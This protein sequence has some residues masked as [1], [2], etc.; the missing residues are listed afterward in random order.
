MPADQPRTRTVG[1]KMTDSEYE[2]L[3]AGAAA[4]TYVPG[5]MALLRQA[6]DFVRGVMAKT[7]ATVPQNPAGYAGAGVRAAY[8]IL[9]AIW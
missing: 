3:A 1:C 9:K 8:K 6:P 2:R 7:P 4:D 5:G